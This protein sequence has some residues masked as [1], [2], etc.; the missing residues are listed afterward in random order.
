[1]ME[2]AYPRITTRKVLSVPVCW[3]EYSSCSGGASTTI[4]NAG[5]EKMS[6][7][8]SPRKP[9][10]KEDFRSTCIS[11]CC[12]GV[13]V[14]TLVIFLLCAYDIPASKVSEVEPWRR[15]QLRFELHQL[16]IRLPHRPWR[17]LQASSTTT[18]AAAAA[19]A[20][21]NESNS[22]Q[23]AAA[24]KLLREQE[25]EQEVEE[26]TALEG[27]GT[28]FRRGKRAMSELLVAHLVEN[29]TTR[30][31]R[32]FLRTLH[33]SGMTARV[34]VVLLFPWRPLPAAMLDVI[35]EE[36]ESF[37][38]LL[39]SSSRPLVVGAE[40]YRQ[41]IK[42]SDMSTLSNPDNIGTTAAIPAAPSSANISVFNA[43]AFRKW[44]AADTA[45]SKTSRSGRS[46]WGNPRA[47]RVGEGSTAEAEEDDG[48][49]YGA[50]VGFDIQELDPADA[51]RAF[52]NEPPAALRRWI[53]YQILLGMVRQKYRH[54]MLSEVKG[55]LILKDMLAPLKKKDIGLYV[56]AKDRRWDENENENHHV[57]QLLQHG[58]QQKLP[59]LM[60]QVYGKQVWDS[61]EKEEKRRLRVLSSGV[62]MGGMRSV[63]SLASAMATEV[64]RVAILRKSAQQFLINDE[65]ILSYLVHKS[66]ALGRKVASHLHIVLASGD[67][68]SINL[69]SDG[70]KQQHQ[71]QW[72]RSAFFRAHENGVLTTRFALIQGYCSCS[73]GT[74]ASC[75]ERRNSLLASLHNDIC[76]SSRLL[77]DHDSPVYRDCI[78]QEHT[79]ELQSL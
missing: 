57:P 77:A 15:P 6:S 63:R 47:A 31:L 73:D 74:V 38:K 13:L 1:M 40:A 3:D 44:S 70:S 4:I 35:R 43:A 65:A 41:S 78:G 18:V 34:D 56:F 9:F 16:D 48:S 19:A 49:S 72:T 17:T 37:H 2:P 10:R 14:F 21:N 22:I 45:M 25:R 39:T 42:L 53:C 58:G 7:S 46:V 59:G 61:L 75:E 5:A 79:V 76:F 27:M 51:M 11:L 52:I 62:M 64:V 32:L 60:E 66:S 71:L 20:I 50:I 36:E 29:T 67:S 33:R 24:G 26:E 8:C 68:S 30:D 28:L 54:V 23:Q 55:V 69:L 12:S